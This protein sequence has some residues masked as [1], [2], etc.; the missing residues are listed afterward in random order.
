VIQV[1]DIEQGT[2]EWAKLRAGLY[3]GSNAHKLLAHAASTKIVNGEATK[4]ALTEQSSL[5]GNFWTKRGHLLED[6]A[7]ELYRAI[8]GHDVSRPGF[9]TN[10]NYPGCGYS[11]DGSDDT[12][13]ANLEV[14]CFDEG[15]HMK[16]VRG[17]IDL[18]ILA[19]IHFGLTIW[20][21]NI[22]KLIAYCPRVED[23]KLA[24]KVIEIKSKSAIKKNFQRIL[25]P[26]AA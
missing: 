11:P 14:K 26:E 5:Q 9:I 13:T 1:H 16:L 18:K 6:E 17:D 12:L 15:P 7:I 19:Q 20:E 2:D 21:R 24:F 10:S 4:Y 23:P 3:T 22:A 25:S 8:T